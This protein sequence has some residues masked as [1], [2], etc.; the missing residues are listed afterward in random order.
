VTAAGAPR[1]PLLGLLFA[2]LGTRTSYTYS[3]ESTTSHH[4][5]FSFRFWL[6]PRPV[7]LNV[8]HFCLDF[9]SLLLILHR[10][11]IPYEWMRCVCILSHVYRTIHLV[12]SDCL[13]SSV[14]SLCLGGVAR[15]GSSGGCLLFL[16]N[17]GS[18]SREKGFG[19]NNF[20]IRRIRYPPFYA[21][22]HC[23]RQQTNFWSLYNDLCNFHTVAFPE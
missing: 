17:T 3:A 6:R 11:L 10:Q 23:Q 14:D 16:H 2:H 1:L 20:L 22:Q 15:T 21:V 13:N 4:D 7:A 18:I 19:N 8:V 5:R 12:S 9:L